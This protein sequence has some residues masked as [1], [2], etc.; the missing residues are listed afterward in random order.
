MTNELRGKKKKPNYVCKRYKNIIHIWEPV[1][2]SNYYYII[3]KDYKEFCVIAKKCLDCEP[4]DAD[5]EPMGHT[6]CFEKKGVGTLV[7]IWTKEHKADVIAHEC[8]HAVFQELKVRGVRLSM[9]SDELYCY[10]LQLLMKSIL[11]AL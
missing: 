10:M 3:A 11:E 1:F 5:W 6:S 2:Q 9:D 4:Q 8:F 7:L